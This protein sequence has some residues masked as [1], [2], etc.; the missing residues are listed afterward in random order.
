M[1]LYILLLECIIVWIQLSVI[2]GVL[3]Y[4]VCLLNH[5]CIELPL[6]NEGSG[7]RTNEKYYIQET[8]HVAK[9]FYHALYDSFV[10]P[11]RAH[12]SLEPDSVERLRVFTKLDVLEAV[13]VFKEGELRKS[14][15]VL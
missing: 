13:L 3:L 5:G 10:D 4:G 11:I 8:A 7:H 6:D 9:V 14:V 12:I 15:G 2:F 1:V